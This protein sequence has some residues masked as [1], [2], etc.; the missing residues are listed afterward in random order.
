MS[1]TPKGYG[2]LLGATY[3]QALED[4]SSGSSR[5]CVPVRPG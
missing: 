3:K 1:G 2:N 5:C 4:T